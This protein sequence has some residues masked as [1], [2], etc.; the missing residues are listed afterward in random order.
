MLLTLEARDLVEFEE[1]GQI[2]HMG[3]GALRLGSTFLRRTNLVDRAR[4]ILR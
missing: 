2:W 1:D 4:P 3:P